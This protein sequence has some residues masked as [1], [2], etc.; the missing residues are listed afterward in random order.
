MDRYGIL[1]GKKALPPLEV[2]I[3]RDSVGRV[4]SNP[5]KPF[6]WME[7]QNSELA[8]RIYEDFFSHG[9]KVAESLDILGS[10]V[11]TV[12]GEIARI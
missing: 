3:Q 11:S 4:V 2:D 8:K 5:S 7:Y 9:N 10:A 6:A 12:Q 1:L